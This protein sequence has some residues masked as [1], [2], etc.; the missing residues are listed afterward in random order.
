M[1]GSITPN[2]NNDA[3]QLE[4]GETISPRTIEAASEVPPITQ[5]GPPATAMSTAPAVSGV[6]ETVNPHSV[7]MPPAGPEGSITWTASEFI[8]HHKS[9]GWYLILGSSALVVA[10]IIWLLTRDTI[11]SIVVIV[12]A[13]TFGFYGARQPRQLQ[14][15]LDGRGLSIGQRHFFYEQ[16]RSFSIMPEGAVSSIVFMPLKRFAMLTTIYYDP[17]DEPKIID[18]LIDRLP[19]EDRQKD[20]FDRLL[21]RIRF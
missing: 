17:A 9:P 21:W 6:P 11:T 1:D 20:M 12:A 4:P 18:L 14:Y 5:P 19:H 2:T 8:A 10:I 13:I 15:S 3:D 7:A 16:F